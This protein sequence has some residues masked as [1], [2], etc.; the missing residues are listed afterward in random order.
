MREAMTI[1]LPD[2]QIAR[3]DALAAQTGRTKTF[4]I[5][6]AVELYLDSVTTG[7]QG[8]VWYQAMM[9]GERPYRQV[10]TGKWTVL[11]C[12]A[13]GDDALFGQLASMEDVR[14]AGRMVDGQR[15]SYWCYQREDQQVLAV[16]DAHRRS[17]LILGLIPFPAVDGSD[18]ENDTR[19][20]VYP[21]GL[22][23][24]PA[25]ACGARVAVIRKEKGLTQQEFARMLGTSGSAL[26]F[27]ERGRR[28][29]SPAMAS[30]MAKAL[31]VPLKRILHG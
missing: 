15:A 10:G 16:V 27:M 23:Y 11:A 12:D 22:D 4:F 26:S 2:K 5:Q 1:R 17:A 20:T 28:P 30:R 8:D 29:V 6:R 25:L 31:G 24:R 18:L 7:Y 3:L 9:D 14:V 21:D 19:N 13:V